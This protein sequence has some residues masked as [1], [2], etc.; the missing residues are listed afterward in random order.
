M[1]YRTQGQAEFYTEERCHITEILNTAAQEQVSVAQARVE[2]HVTTAWHRVA[3]EE[4]YYLLTGSG[5]ME[6]EG[7]A[8]PATLHPG[9]LAV[10]PAGSAQRITNLLDVDLVFLCICVPRFQQEKYTALE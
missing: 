6:I 2:P 7:M 1:I 5:R 9:D 4:L 3:V 10:I 8:A